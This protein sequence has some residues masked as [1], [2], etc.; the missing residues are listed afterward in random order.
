MGT[1]T[2]SALTLVSSQKPAETWN[3]AGSKTPFPVLQLFL[4]FIFPLQS[5]HRVCTVVSSV[6]FLSHP[7][8][9]ISQI[10]PLTA[11]CSR[12]LFEE[13]FLGRAFRESSSKISSVTYQRRGVKKKK[14]RKEK[15]KPLKKS[16]LYKQSRQFEYDFIHWSQGLEAGKNTCQIWTMFVSSCLVRSLW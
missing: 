9:S 10:L 11:K 6:W 3:T 15:E 4:L 12:T 7:G 8:F 13:E 5:A 1:E 16:P 2:G 14:K